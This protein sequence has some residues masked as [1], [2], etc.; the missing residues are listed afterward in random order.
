[1][2]FLF[3]FLQRGFGGSPRILAREESFFYQS[4]KFVLLSLILLCQ[5]LLNANPF[6]FSTDI[7]TPVLVY[8]IIAEKENISLSLAFWT[9]LLLEGASFFPFGFYFASYG[10]FW[11]LF[12]AIREHIRWQN[13]STWLGF[14]FLSQALLVGMEF[15]LSFIKLSLVSSETILYFISSIFVRFVISVFIVA[16]LALKGLLVFPKG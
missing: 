12:T 8:F 6:P 16:L 11:L 1:M 9:A 2:R 4:S 5:M 15:I 10:C 3:E 13:A 7:V 14:L